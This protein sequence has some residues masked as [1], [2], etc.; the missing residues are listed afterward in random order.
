MAT[1]MGKVGII[2]L[3]ILIAALVIGTSLFLEESNN[4]R[5]VC[6][7]KNHTYV[8]IQRSG[9]GTCCLFD[10]QSMTA[11]CQDFEKYNKQYYLRT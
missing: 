6:E 3:A 9:E 2:G 11:V 7:S 5:K 4:L 8:G 1:D 10:N